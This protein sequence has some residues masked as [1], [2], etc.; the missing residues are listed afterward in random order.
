MKF[1]EKI[2][3]K[4]QTAFLS[5]PWS[6]FKRRIHCW[7]LWKANQLWIFSK[8]INVLSFVFRLLYF[9]SVFVF[10]LCLLSLSLFLFYFV[11]FC[12][13]FWC[14]SLVVNILKKVSTFDLFF[15][16]WSFVFVCGVPAQLWVFSKS[17]NVWSFILKLRLNAID[18]SCSITVNLVAL[19]VW[20]SFDGLFKKVRF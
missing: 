3:K 18:P 4:N 2:Y 15:W 5:W 10:V 19:W 20:W 13:C 16:Y 14:A 11:L 1:Y 12:L 8:G 6:S 9:I 17:F 7:W